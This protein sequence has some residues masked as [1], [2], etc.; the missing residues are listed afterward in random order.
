MSAR[1]GAAVEGHLDWE[2]DQSK[3]GHYCGIQ[4]P[5][6]V[7]HGQKGSCTCGRDEL[8]ARALAAEAESERLTGALE[9]IAEPLCDATFRSRLLRQGLST[10]EIA[11]YVEAVEANQQIARQALTHPEDSPREGGGGTP[12][13]CG[14]DICPPTS[15]C[16]VCR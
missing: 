10:D 1:E 2:P 4:G 13:S 11:Q 15:D 12:T 9:R 3:H 7:G 8:V 5:H 6:S 14:R 16:R